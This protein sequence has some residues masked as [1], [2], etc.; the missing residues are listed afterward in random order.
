M[1]KKTGD[2]IELLNIKTNIEEDNK[3]YTGY[4]KYFLIFFF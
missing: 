2:F 1:R 4:E 3:K